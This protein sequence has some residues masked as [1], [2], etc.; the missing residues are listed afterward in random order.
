MSEDQGQQR[1]IDTM[2]FFNYVSE[3][4]DRVRQTDRVDGAKDLLTRRMRAMYKQGMELGEATGRRE[5]K[6]KREEGRTDLFDARAFGGFVTLTARR[7]V[8]EKVDGRSKRRVEEVTRGDLT[9][10]EGRLLGLRLIKLADEADEQ[11]W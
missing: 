4:A 3:T 7:E 11:E 1:Y 9:P 2:Q 6:E 10:D 5:L 8:W